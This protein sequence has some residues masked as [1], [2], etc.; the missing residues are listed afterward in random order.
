LKDAAVDLQNCSKECF[1]VLLRFDYNVKLYDEDGMVVAEPTEARRMFAASPNLMVSLSDSDDDSSI[2]LLFGKSTH[3]ND[4]G[5]LMQ[6]LRTTATKYNL[7][8]KP[9]QFGKEID[10]KDYQNM[11]SV[12]ESKR[13]IEMHVCEG[14]YGTS[15]TSYLTLNKAKM[16]VHHNER[17]S[18]TRPGGR[19]QHIGRIFIENAAGVR[20]QFPTSELS[21]A[22]KMTE[23][24]NAGG[25]FA[26]ATGKTILRTLEKKPRQF[27]HRSLAENNPVVREF[28][29]WTEQFAPHRALTEWNEPDHQID[30]HHEDATDLAI[31]HFDPADFLA[32]SEWHDTLAGRSADPM[33]GESELGKDEVMDALCLYMRHF[34]ET[35]SDHFGETG[36]DD[37][38]ESLAS[39]VYDQAAE[40]IQQSGYTIADDDGSDGPHDDYAQL[41]ASPERGG[42]FTRE[43]ILLPHPNQGDSLA[44]EVSKAMVHDDPTDR[45]KEHPVNT[46]YLSRLKTLAG[47]DSSRGQR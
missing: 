33:D 14:L 41:E 39:H 17:I 45:D 23:H 32:S 47:V 25:E 43:D 27:D 20:V 6:A 2:T 12:S 9:K 34:V 8:F 38:D 11:M 10:A 3:A 5:G 28:M 30:H 36:F 26:D 22:R 16:I 13:E 35:H 1:Q 7:T 46:E 42:E 18:A 19:A 21:A 40:A 29:L 44:G 37:D 4:I 24:L 31:D 15:R